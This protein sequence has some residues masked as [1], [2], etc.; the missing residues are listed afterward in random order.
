[1]SATAFLHPAL[2][3]YIPQ[4]GEVFDNE[5]AVEDFDMFND[6]ISS[7]MKENIKLVSLL[8]T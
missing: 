5:P 3:P 8:L 6:D 1:M 7:S 2:K 4:E